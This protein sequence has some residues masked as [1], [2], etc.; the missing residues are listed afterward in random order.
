MML[1]NVINSGDIKMIASFLDIYG[2]NL[3]PNS[4][5]PMTGF[6]NSFRGLS[7]IQRDMLGKE[8]PIGL[9]GKEAIIAYWNCL[10]KIFPD[11]VLYIND[12]K[13]KTNIVQP[14]GSCRLEFGFRLETTNLFPD[15]DPGCI[16]KNV[17]DM[18][19]LQSPNRTGTIVSESDTSSEI[20]DQR[21]VGKKRKLECSIS[22]QEISLMTNPHDIKALQEE[23]PLEL[24]RDFSGKLPTFLPSKQVVRGFFFMWVN[25]D[26]RI[27]RIGI[28]GLPSV[29]KPTQAGTN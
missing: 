27:E 16:G 25:A 3:N 23:S 18:L 6:D 4:L 21:K 7:L 29:E 17:S 9:H 19:L 13:L 1:T 24:L 14:D 11:H 5:L 2:N 8:T 10:L 15:V 26:K 28:N 12:I 22:S 20:V